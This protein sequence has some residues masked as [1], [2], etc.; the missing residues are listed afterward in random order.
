MN[1][2]IM[3]TYLCTLNKCM[4]VDRVYYVKHMHP[5]SV[6]IC[7]IH[8]NYCTIIIILLLYIISTHQTHG[9]KIPANL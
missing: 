6:P 7:Y 3:Y 1:Y 2:N 5:T 8:H 4:C 9:K